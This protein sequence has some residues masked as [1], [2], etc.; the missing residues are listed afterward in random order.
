[1]GC[2]RYPALARSSSGLTILVWSENAKWKTGGSLA[3]QVYDRDGAPIGARGLG[4]EVPDWS[5]A[6][7]AAREG[8]GFT[9]LY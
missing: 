5:F 6:A 8:G 3:W 1:M 4:P 9:V 7:V 2:R